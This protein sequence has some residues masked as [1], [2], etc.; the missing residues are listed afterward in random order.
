M[1]ICTRALFLKLLYDQPM[2]ATISIGLD[3]GSTTIKAVAIDT[4]GEIIHKD[5]RRHY[6]DISGSLK[7]VLGELHDQFVGSYIKLSITGS[8]G[9]GIAERSG[10]SFV[11][12][13]VASSGLIMQKFP[14]VKTFV[15]IGG[16]DSKMVFF[17]KG[18]SP[19][20][21]MNGNCAGGTGAFLDQIASILGI[22]VDEISG[23]AEKS[24]IIYPVASRCGVFAKTDVQNLLSRNV[25]KNDIAASVLHALCVQLLASL[26][27]GYMPGPPIFICGGPFTYIPR[28]R[29]AF[30]KAIGVSQGD[31]ILSEHSA[32]I[33]A[34]GAALHASEIASSH[35]IQDFI[36]LL[37]NIN[38]SSGSEKHS[39]LQPLFEDHMQALELIESNNKV[40]LP[41][42]KIEDIK[43]DSCFLGI[44][45]GS[46]TT[47]II[48]LDQQGSI[49]FRF[50]EKNQGDALLTTAKGLQELNRMALQANKSLKVRAGCVT[51]Y[52]EDLIRNAYNLDYGLVETVA[53]F[54]AAA[55]INPNVSFILDIGGQDMKAVFIK[56]KVIVRMEI[57]EA[58]SSGCGSF[59]ETFAQGLNHTVDDF[60][61]IACFSRNPC[62]LGTRCT[63]FMN[64]K[65]KQA[66]RE[67]AEIADIS[68]GLGFSIIKNCLNKVLKLKDF[69]P[70]GDHIMVQ[71]G[72][73]RNPSIIRALELES[74]KKIMVTDHPE[75]MGAYG[76][77]LY[78]LDRSSQT[79]GDISV[80]LSDLIKS[81]SCP[82]KTSICKHCANHCAVTRFKFD[83]G[84]TYFSG[85]KCEKIFC[86]RGESL[87]SGRN[88]YLEKYDL[89]FTRNTDPNPGS[90]VIGVPRALGLY[91]NY[92]FWHT[93]LTHCG[94]NV[95]LSDD[96]TMQLYEKGANTVMSDNIC[97]PA[98][99]THGHVLNLI[100]KNVDRIFMPFVVHEKKDDKNS[101]NSYNCPIVTGY[102]EVIKSAINPQ[103]KHQI[104]IDA[105]SI[106]FKDKYLLKKACWNYLSSLSGNAVLKK[107]VFEKAFKNALEQQNNFEDTMSQTAEEIVDKAMITG[108]TLILLAG[109][110]YHSDPLI[111]HKIADMVA[112]FGAD[113]IS[114]DIVRHLDSPT[115]F[116]HNVMQWELSNRIIKAA[117]WVA[118]APGN[119]HFMQFTSFGCGPDAFIMD[120]VTGILD[121][122]NK[123]PTFL[124]IDDINN[125]G[126]MRLRVRSLIES[127]KLNNSNREVHEKE[128]RKTKPFQKPDRERKLLMPWFG[129]FYSPFFPALLSLM[130]YDA[131]NLPPSDQE[132]VE[133]GLIH[134]NN[135]VCYPATLVIG[136][137]MK[138]LLSGRYDRNKIVLGISQ[139]GGQCRATNY[140]ALLKKA[141]VSAGFDDVPVIAIA[142][143]GGRYNEQPGFEF[144]WAKIFNTLVAALSYAD[145]LS[146]M[147]FASAPRELHSGTAE[148]IKNKYL[149]L[150][151]QA[152]M[153]K[154]PRQ[155]LKLAA[156]AAAE[157]VD[158]IEQV[159]IPRIG[160]G[161][162]IFVKY[163]SF[164]NKNILNWLVSRGIEPVM[165][166]F[167][168]FFL[169]GFAS[170]EARIADH[171]ETRKQPKFIKD[172]FEK[173]IFKII[174][175]MEEQI[176]AF[177]Y[178]RPIG[179]PHHEA[180]AASEIINLN[181]QF[182]EGWLV[183]ASFARFAQEGINNVVSLQPFG[184]IANHIVSKGIEKRTKDL[185]P[186]LNLL[187][188]DMDSGMS[189]ANIF[190]RLHFMACNAERDVYGQPALT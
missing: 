62:N 174:R 153:A 183:P 30:S 117:E 145:C 44:D 127:L 99:L 112:G 151:I 167:T 29:Q 165:P 182:G 9:M 122:K 89:L 115:N 38:T 93:L 88:I 31:L 137:F 26:A 121:R 114:E 58:C 79:M 181:A 1:E 8:A 173:K 13:M 118:N 46:T 160:I 119:V 132:S 57:N 187:F 54:T 90:I 3:V 48:A 42:T 24:T 59:L 37:E 69:S 149:Q 111:Q 49:F 81:V 180:K 4:F 101:L 25:S 128:F 143:G 97:F 76:A 56:D 148:R 7:N 131:E 190:N 45:S 21:R 179:N 188:L 68:A 107:P 74:G 52:G 141:M 11:Q 71:G 96:S 168:E 156:S 95:V 133:H 130:G 77:A 113:V 16:E 184:C 87:V 134:T 178:Y 166:P 164:S 146:G 53:H 64:S 154:M 116:T 17:E 18:K 158:A 65:V 120:E 126:S 176:A 110:P 169:E 10:I 102:P 5:Y 92:P 91:E 170:S 85:N 50:Y 159:T 163:H 147:Y 100:E 83:N 40:R 35:K 36:H 138:A 19:D 144:R 155:L 33:P 39:R 82:S 15:D 12:E 189:E 73:F 129:D 80:F 124:K 34:W 135:E 67:G 23:L 142:I 157:F 20:M 185:Y 123:N 47:K 94:L 162:E 66:L 70:L 125:I 43:S 27:R 75:L 150:G 63:V 2:N 61:R 98:K 105:P 186:Q 60:A 108:R 78:A 177:P 55:H 28:L 172:I 86:N 161:G 22:E 14:Q 6:A 41:K 104:P 175:E 106:T 84:K 139:T 51:G 136:D 152:I 72:T 109:R 32:V 140:I 171:L 103:G